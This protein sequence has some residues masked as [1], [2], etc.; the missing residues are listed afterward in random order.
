[1]FKIE[2]GLTAVPRKNAPQNRDHGSNNLL[3]QRFKQFKEG[4]VNFS[5][6]AYVG[7]K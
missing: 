5:D 3:G 7:K 6:F 2:R 4:L 1:M